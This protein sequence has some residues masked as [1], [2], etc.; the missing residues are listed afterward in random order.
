VSEILPPE[1]IWARFSD[2]ARIAANL[3]D[4]KEWPEL[5][6]I[7]PNNIE[8]DTGKLLPYRT[9]R[10]DG[11]KSANHHFYSGQLLYSKIRPYLNKCARVDFDGLCSA[12]MYP[13]DSL[14]E[15][16]FLHQYILTHQF[17]SE[18][19]DAAGSRTVLPKTNQKQMA[20]VPVPVAP[21]GEQRR[22]VAALDSYFARLDDATA[23][24]NRVQA[25]LKRYRASVLKSAVEGRLVP[26]EAGLAREEGRDYEPASVLLARILVERRR[27]WEEAE[28]AKLVAKGKPPKNDKWK[29]KYKVPAEPDTEG[30]PELPEGWCW[31]TAHQLSRAEQYSLAIGPFGSN[32]KVSDYREAGVPLVFVRNIRAAKFGGVGDR[33][34][35]RDKAAELLA[36]SVEAGDILV[37]KMGE[38]PGDPCLYPAG[39]PLAIITADCIK[40]RLASELVPQFY[41]A[42]LRSLSVRARIVTITQGVAQKKISLARFRRLIVPVPPALEQERLSEEVALRQSIID[43]TEH[44]AQL[45]RRRLERLRQSIL[46]WAFEGKLVDQDPND[47]PASVLLERIKAER[48]AAAAKAKPKKQARRKRSAKK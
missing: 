37:T 29:A 11:V 38:P 42:A 26:T 21:V 4:P 12:D 46:K 48:E 3:V 24:L 22:I 20:E 28:L 1:W 10:D 33:S 6:H 43:R 13:L 7:A 18:V 31:A 15:R 34:V 23:T 27:R 45:Q 44:I 19:S 36:H 32:L 17:V 8:R 9:V 5:P 16:S 25:N 47:E 14:V 2:V 39:S 40:W 41:V 35:S 30:L